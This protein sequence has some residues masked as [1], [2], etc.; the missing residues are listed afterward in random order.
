MKKIII[1]CIS[2]ILIS[3]GVLK[4]SYLNGPKVK[5]INK[6]LPQYDLPKQFSYLNN[7][8]ILSDLTKASGTRNNNDK[9]AITYLP[10]QIPGIK[11]KS[12]YVYIM[13]DIVANQNDAYKLFTD[14]VH[15]REPWNVNIFWE[16]NAYYAIG[17]D[18]QYHTGYLVIGTYDKSTHLARKRIYIFDLDEKTQLWFQN[19]QPKQDHTYNQ[20]MQNHT[21]QM[22]RE[23]L[24]LGQ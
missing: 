14:Q 19:N 1:C 8:F 23:L 6:T 5:T 21:L 11:P 3:C 16:N 4:D 24:L 2:L 15:R 12:N 17:E 10:C 22:V 18:K 9:R 7:T 13:D 20:P